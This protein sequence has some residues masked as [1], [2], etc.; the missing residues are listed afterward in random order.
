M[1][2][3]PIILDSGSTKLHKV[4]QEIYIIIHET[5]SEASESQESATLDSDP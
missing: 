3:K 1:I 4:F 2:P 5:Y